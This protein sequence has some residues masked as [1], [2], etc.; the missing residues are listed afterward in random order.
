MT[1]RDTTKVDCVSGRTM[2]ESELE[3][4]INNIRSGKALG[5]DYIRVERFGHMRET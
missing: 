3:A 4:T 1:E 5:T 2:L